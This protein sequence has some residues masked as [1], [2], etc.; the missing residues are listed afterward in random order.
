MDCLENVDV[1]LG[2]Y[3]TLTDADLD[4]ATFLLPDQDAAFVMLNDQNDKFSVVFFA[5]FCHGQFT[6]LIK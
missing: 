3:M 6:R 5:F 1:F 4:H 2:N